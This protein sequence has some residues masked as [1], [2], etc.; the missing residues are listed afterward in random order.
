M[1][2]RNECI[3]PEQASEMLKFNVQ[4]RSISRDYVSYLADQMSKGLWQDNGETIKIARN[5]NILDGQHR[6]LAIVKSGQAIQMSVAYEV[7]N[8][9]FLS[10][11]RG[12]KRT[13]GQVFE[14]AKIKNGKDVAATI[15]YVQNI[16]SGIRN[17]GFAKGTSPQELISIYLTDPEG[18]SESSLFGER[19][20]SVGKRV[21]RQTI[22]SGFHYVL[23]KKNRELVESF[24]KEVGIGVGI[25]NVKSPTNQ[26]RSRFLEQK[27]KNFKH[28][29]T[30]LRAY[31]IKAWNAY[32]NNKSA[33]LKFDPDI[34][35]FPVL[36]K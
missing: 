10:I 4:N 8:D 30:Q 6:L 27:T 23:K 36:L 29:E 18:F 17:S 3:T 9:F 1:K 13:P 15:R 24:W 33:Y 12:L 21:V 14:I 16:E 31:I 34:E 32:K 7:E 28:N 26:L 35:S 11:D 5:G 19:I 25:E 20:S 22:V 2:L